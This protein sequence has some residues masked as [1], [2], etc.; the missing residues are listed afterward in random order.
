MEYTSLIDISF[1]AGLFAGEGCVTNSGHKALYISMGMCD[2]Y[3][4][5]CSLEALTSELGLPPKRIGVRAPRGPNHKVL[6][7]WAFTGYK[8]AAICQLLYPYL[9]DTEKGKQMERAFEKDSRFSL[10]EPVDAAIVA[11]TRGPMTDEHKSKIGAA[12]KLRH[13]KR[14]Q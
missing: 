14:V 7:Y 2:E 4:I 3:S 11:R 1:V 8:A 10:G 12:L 6:W 13:S 5:A 9:K